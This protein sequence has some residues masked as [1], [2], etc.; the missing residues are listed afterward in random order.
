MTPRHAAALSG[1][2]LLC[3][4]AAPVAQATSITFDFTTLGTG[5]TSVLDP[6]SSPA[7]AAQMGVSLRVTAV[8]RSAP[9]GN[10]PPNQFAD[11]DVTYGTGG[12][13]AR[14][15]GADNHELDSMGPDEALRFRILSLPGGVA[16]LRLEEVVF[17]GLTISGP[18]PA[19][20]EEFTL[21]IDNDSIIHTDITPSATSPWIVANDI[22]SAAD[23]TGSLNFR[24]QTH[25]DSPSENDS[26]RIASLTFELVPATVA[27]PAAL[28][29]FGL[30][31]AGL[32]L[33]ARRGGKR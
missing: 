20:I 7:L 15:N 4:L 16:A 12:L 9:T 30:G 22:A 3:L 11:I 14:V 5:V 1:T 17:T 33:A 24:F 6:S 23:R 28:G 26:F 27:E 10:P 21:T 2:A 19:A 18:P 32:G 8:N 31:L 13:G 25:S 29:L